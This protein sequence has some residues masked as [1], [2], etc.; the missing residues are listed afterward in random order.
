M[1]IECCKGGAAGIRAEGFYNL[2]AVN[3]SV[4]V[5]IIGLIKSQFDDGYVCISR[6]FSKIT[7]LYNLGLRIIA[8]DGTNRKFMGLSGP[9]FIQLCN[10]SFP[11]M[12]I[13]ADI[14]SID[15][16]ITAHKAGADAVATTLRGYTPQTNNLHTA[17]DF[18]FV[19]QLKK[20]DASLKIIAEGKVNTPDI[21]M[22]LNDIG[23]YSIV[24]GKSITD[25]KFIV[26]SYLNPL[27]T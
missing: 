11:D 17:F 24:I 3:G 16:A 10:K 6:D 4:D 9:E 25:P 5:P 27:I 15:S 8:V 21:L 2:K 20:E 23:V 19:N 22:K 13:I 18:N 12:E 1:A 26:D 7:E 14:D